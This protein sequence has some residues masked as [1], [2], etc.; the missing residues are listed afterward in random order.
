ML[1]IALKCHNTQS[2]Q[3]LSHGETRIQGSGPDVSDADCRCFTPGPHGQYR[4]P[5]TARPR[6]G[7]LLGLVK[8]PPN[9]SFAGSLGDGWD[10][11]RGRGLRPRR[12]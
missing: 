11:A 4:P 5:W 3:R 12:V 6:E 1:R 10:H 8:I 2:S 7:G 9:F